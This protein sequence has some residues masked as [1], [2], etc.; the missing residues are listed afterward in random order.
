MRLQKE[1][2]AFLASSVQARD[3][4]D[5]PSGPCGLKCLAPWKRGGSGVLLH[6]LG[7]DGWDL[8]LPKALCFLLRPWS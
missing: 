2:T 3:Q 8:S 4:T 7:E 1:G 6:L 5:N